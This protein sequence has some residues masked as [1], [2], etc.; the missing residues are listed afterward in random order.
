MTRKH[1]QALADAM[2][3]TQPIAGPVFAMAQWRADVEAVADVLRQF[4]SNFDR[5][6]FY[7]A[8]DYTR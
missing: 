1:F 2:K 3:S 6:R 4:N 8:C 7:A 5:E